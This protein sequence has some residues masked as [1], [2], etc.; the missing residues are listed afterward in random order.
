MVGLDI[1]KLIL[2]AVCFI[3]FFSWKPYAWYSVMAY[4]WVNIG[5]YVFAIIVFVLVLSTGYIAA[6]ITFICMKF[7]PYLIFSICA[8][9]Y[10]IKRKPL[11]F[12]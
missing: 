2:T 12:D 10:Y 7:A 3:G 11:F 4:L 5:Y 9:A 1:V 6:D 8:S